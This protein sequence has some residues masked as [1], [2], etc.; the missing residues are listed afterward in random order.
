VAALLAWAGLV[1]PAAA[2]PP[3][4]AP[5]YAIKAVFLFNFAQF[6]DWP[7]TAFASATSPIVIG[8]LGDDPFGP[9]LDDLVRPEKIGGR[10]LAVRRFR[11]PE[12]VGECQI[13]FVSRALAGRFDQIKPRLAG[14]NL[15]TVADVEGFCQQGGI[16]LFVTENGKIRLR[17]NTEA[18]KA[19][20][21]TISSKLL[22]SATLYTP[23]KGGP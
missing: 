23:E 8:V 14:R 9:Y 19:A 22:R 16:V 13:L 6:V 1:G 17:I 21:L 10:P 18:A 7:E 5:E 11:R 4:P 2:A 15:L 12:E 3:A 20:G